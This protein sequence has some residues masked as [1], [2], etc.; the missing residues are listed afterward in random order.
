MLKLT[1]ILSIVLSFTAM[2]STSHPHLSEVPKACKSEVIPN[3]FKHH[4]DFAPDLRAQ[5]AYEESI[6]AIANGLV[7]L[8]EG[9]YT[10]SSKFKPTISTE[11]APIN[12][13]PYNAATKVVV[14]PFELEGF[15]DL[16]VKTVS[17]KC[18]NAYNQ[19]VVTFVYNVFYSYGGNYRGKGKYLSSIVIVPSYVQVATG[20]TFTSSM[21]VSSVTNHSTTADPVAGIF[22]SMKYSVASLFAAVEKNDTIYIKGDGQ[23]KSMQ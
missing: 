19:T 4:S 17:T 16:V 15:S 1:I 3:T 10:L 13:V 23:F 12:V 21:K 2:A 6:I 9:I 7:A 14:S 20:W 22:L 8:G 18:M 11:Y 5:P